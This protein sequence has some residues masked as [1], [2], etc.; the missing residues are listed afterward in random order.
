M[1]FP[2]FVLG[3]PRSGTSA[4]R[5]HLTCHRDLEIPPE[6]SFLTW[7]LPKYADWSVLDAHD[8]RIDEFVCDVFNSRK[9]STWRLSRDRL[10]QQIVSSTPA[11]YAQLAAC[12]YSAYANQRCKPQARWGDKNNVHLNKVQEISD[13]YPNA[14]FILVTRDVRDILVS[15]RDLSKLDSGLRFR[16]Q[17]PSDAL[18]LA[19]LWRQ[20]N[21][22]A[23][24]EL[25]RLPHGSFTTVSFEELVASPRQ[26]LESLVRFLH[27]EWDEEIMS[28]PLLNRT[29]NLE[30]QETMY[31]KSLT[32][33]PLTASRVGRW[34]KALSDGDLRMVVEEGEPL[35]TQLG[36][37]FE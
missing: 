5:L 28:A 36:Y 18:R 15:V 8:Q 17:L 14:Q 2:F 10:R 22:L 16:P 26:V 21:T 24:R 34:R 20:Q 3:F 6:S 4:L 35:F 32:L 9:F 27:C 1:N 33:Q 19:T 37:R 12:V 11:N 13:L 23:L 30:P 29:H 25:R 7:L 31:W